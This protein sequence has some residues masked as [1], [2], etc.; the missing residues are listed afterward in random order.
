MTVKIGS[1]EFRTG[2][3]M[4]TFHTPGNGDRVLEVAA[5]SIKKEGYTSAVA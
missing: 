4:A 3:R 2:N 1:H 5:Y